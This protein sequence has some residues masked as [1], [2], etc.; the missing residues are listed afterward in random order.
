MNAFKNRYIFQNVWL[1][2]NKYYVLMSKTSI[3]YAAAELES[4][5]L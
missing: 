5:L 3:C 4:V 1:M 2:K